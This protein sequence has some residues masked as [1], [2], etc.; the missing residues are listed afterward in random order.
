MTAP[1]RMSREELEEEVLYLRREMGLAL[2]A[3]A[4]AA[5]ARAMGMSR[6][7]GVARLVQALHQA[8]GRPVQNWVLEENLYTAQDD[9]APSNLVAVY[10]C[11]AR[12]VLGRDAIAN[13]RAQGY[14]LT[15]VG[16]E[17]VRALL[18]EV[19]A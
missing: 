10:V 6:R 2:D 5:L 9:R 16:M 1:E 8:K 17:R 11:H 15:R 4:L 3:Q 13:H 7:R 12:D 19:A 14:A 18:A